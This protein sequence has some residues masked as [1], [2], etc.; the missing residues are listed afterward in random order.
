[1]EAIVGDDH[2]DDRTAEI[3]SQFSQRNARVSLLAVP[4]P[5][6]GWNG[7][8]HACHVLSQAAKGTVLLFLDADVQLAPDSIPRMIEFMRRSG[9]QLIS[10]VAREICGTFLERLVLPLIHFVLLAYL[11]MQRMWNSTHPSYSAGCG[12][13]SWP[14][15]AAS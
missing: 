11:C 12:H 5:P 3:V 9:V 2:S 4:T 15:N 7:K 14:I 6:A 1:M 10:G 13:F 8:Q